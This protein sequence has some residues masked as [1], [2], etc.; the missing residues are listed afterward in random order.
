[1][2]WNVW[3]CLRV[4]Q[5]ARR[6][7]IQL[8]KVNQQNR[9]SFGYLWLSLK[10]CTI[11]FLH[12]FFA[13]A[14]WCIQFADLKKMNWRIK[15][16]KGEKNA[17]RHKNIC[18]SCGAHYDREPIYSL[19]CGAHLKIKK[20]LDFSRGSISKRHNWTNVCYKNGIAGP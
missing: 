19:L 7:I 3:K 9:K 14:L 6:I 13:S 2:S 10:K 5:V 16:A 4:L 18:L 8:C 12:D 11:S 1:M 20:S 15:S 17:K